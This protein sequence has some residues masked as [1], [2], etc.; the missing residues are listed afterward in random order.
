M[1]SLYIYLHLFIQHSNCNY[2]FLLYDMTL[3]F[4]MIATCMHSKKNLLKCP[5]CVKEEDGFWQISITRQC[6]YTH[7]VL[8]LNANFGDTSRWCRYHFTVFWFFHVICVMPWHGEIS[9]T[10]TRVDSLQ[11]FKATPHAVTHHAM[12]GWWR[13]VTIQSSWNT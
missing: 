4:L 11:H 6:P 10:Q 9:V 5:A 1:L 12:N 7:R 3:P 13:W 8:L 2:P